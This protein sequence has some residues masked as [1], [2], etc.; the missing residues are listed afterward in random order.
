MSERLPRL[1]LEDTL[2]ATNAIFEFT[3][4]MDYDTFLNDR[5]TRD[6]VLRNLQVLGEAAN[7]MPQA[8]RA[9]YPEIE[10]QRIARSRHIIVH[11]YAGIDYEIVWRIS[12][13]HLPPL[14]ITL[15]QAL[16]AI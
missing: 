9:E 14:K 11:D 8:V 5:K 2:E 6:A 7:R 10:W 13:V 3:A 12:E 15:M 16:G 4:G 1:L